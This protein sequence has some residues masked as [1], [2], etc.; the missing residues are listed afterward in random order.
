[1]HFL[2]SVYNPQFLQ[3]SL[4]G[5]LLYLTAEDHAKT[6]IFALPIP[7]TP[8]ASTTHPIL[9]RKFHTP[10][11]LTQ[12]GAASGI[13]PLPGGRLLFSR[14][15]FTSPNDVFLIHDLKT[16]EDDIQAGRSISKFNG[17]IEQIT[18]LTA[19]AL[20]GKDMDEGEEFWFKGA[21][22]KDVQ[23][24]L[25]KPK[26]WHK[27]DKKKWPVVMIIHGGTIPVNCVLSLSTES[28]LN[29]GPHS[30]FGEAWSTRWNQNGLSRP[31]HTALQLTFKPISVLTA[32]VFLDLDES[33]REYGF[34]DRYLYLLPAFLSAEMPIQSLRKGLSTT[35]VVN[36]L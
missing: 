32:G 4:G 2:F 1:V 29:L 12:R 27:N 19:D 8:S 10:I 9:P 26:G 20:K 14:S 17:K 3:F 24:W 30:S 25:F 35:G 28:E 15:S 5:D 7:P 13:Q 6:K 11:A 34:W 31:I 36:R 33:Y 16:F 23:G 22:E 18:H 21:L